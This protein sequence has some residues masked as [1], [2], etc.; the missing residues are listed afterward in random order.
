VASNAG[1]LLRFDPTDQLRMAF[2][3]VGKL[4]DDPLRVDVDIEKEFGNIDPDGDFI[5]CLCYYDGH[6]FL[7]QA[8]HPGRQTPL[9]S[10]PCFG[11]TAAGAERT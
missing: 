11:K 2:A 8:R 6:L 1:R 7:S 5:R 9:V 3:V 10:V 4:P